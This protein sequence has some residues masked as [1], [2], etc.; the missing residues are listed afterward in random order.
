MKSFSVYFSIFYIEYS[1]PFPLDKTTSSLYNKQN[2]IQ[3]TVEA[4]ITAIMPLQRVC[5][6]EKQMR[7]R[8]SNGPLRAQSNVASTEYSATFRQTSYAGG[9]QVSR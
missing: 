1:F 7:N 3:Q 9:M 6:A 8:L 5:V 2:S 4:G